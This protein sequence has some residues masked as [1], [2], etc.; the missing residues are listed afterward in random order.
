MPKEEA[1]KEFKK[2]YDHFLN[3]IKKDLEEQE[4]NR[5]KGSLPPIE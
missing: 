1:L 4:K 5:L 2:N 3:Q